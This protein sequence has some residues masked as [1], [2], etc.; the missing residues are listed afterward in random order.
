MTWRVGGTVTAAQT[1]SKS[2]GTGWPR[3]YRKY[4]L[5]ITQPSQYGCVK[6]QYGFA[7]TSGSPSTV[8]VSIYL[9]RFALPPLLFNVSIYPPSIL[10]ICYRLASIKIQYHLDSSL[11][12]SPCLQPMTKTL[13]R[14]KL[15]TWYLNLTILML[16]V[17]WT[18]TKKLPPHYLGIIYVITSHVTALLAWRDSTT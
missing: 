4:T 18:F 10:P 5:Q 8:Q 17:F 14:S 7:V 15:Y 3:N 12:Y 13:Y 6:S 16:W 2:S 11:I 9:S 1:A